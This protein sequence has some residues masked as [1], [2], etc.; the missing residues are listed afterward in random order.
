MLKM[1]PEVEALQAKAKAGDAQAAAQFIALKW[2]A[3]HPAGTTVTYEKS[4]LE[5]RTILK[6]CGAAYVLGD[7]AVI[8]LEHIGT[9]MLKKTEIYSGSGSAGS[10]GQ[11]NQERIMKSLTEHK[12][13]VVVGGLMGMLVA[14]GLSCV[15]DIAAGNSIGSSIKSNFEHPSPLAL[16]ASGVFLVFWFGAIFAKKR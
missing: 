7:E 3:S 10:R 8:E 4:P 1:T 16:I 15:A 13:W 11:T 6:T 14:A 5:G 12:S 2:N 9:V